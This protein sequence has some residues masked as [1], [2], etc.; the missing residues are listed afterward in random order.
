MSSSSKVISPIALHAL[1]EALSVIYWFKGD[2]KSFLKS[3][4]D[5]TE[6]LDSVNWSD[7]KRK[8]V[9]DVV[10]CLI[11][12]QDRNLGQLRCLIKH[13]VEFNSF[14][15]FGKLEDGQRMAE[16]ARNAVMALKEIVDK[17]D[18]SVEEKK[19]MR[20]KRVEAASKLSQSAAV[21]R[22]LDQIKATYI[23]LVLSLADPHQRGRD[24]ESVMYDIF[25]LFDLDPK[26]SFSIKGEQIDGAF[27]LDGTEYIFEAKWVK[28]PCSREQMDAFSCKISRKLENTLGLFLS[29]NGFSRS[30]VDIHSAGKPQFICMTGSDLMAVIDGRIDLVE[31]L[32]IKKRHAS[33][34]GCILFEVND[35]L[36]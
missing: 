32:R 2:L 25:K 1:K 28:D 7:S 26:A 15:H 3:S 14:R 21:Q 22:G 16:N 11:S 9:T 17:H 12:D 24:L 34:T 23:S 19:E 27:S 35:F 6:L 5:D 10:D 36:R 29:I 18:Q 31:L 33:Q 4:L 8:I 13:V 20:K 30:G